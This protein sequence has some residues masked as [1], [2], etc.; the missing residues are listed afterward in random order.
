MKKTGLFLALISLLNISYG[1]M[2]DVLLSQL[3]ASSDMHVG[4]KISSWENNEWE[5]SGDIV[6]RDDRPIAAIERKPDAGNPALGAKDQQL[7]VEWEKLKT[8]EV[9]LLRFTAVA[10]NSEL[11]V[12]WTSVPTQP[13]NYFLVQRSQHKKQWQDL[14]IIL[15]P[16][17]MQPVTSFRYIDPYPHTGSNYYRLSQAGTRSGIAQSEVIAVEMMENGYHVLHLFPHAA[18]FG[19][20]IGLH[21]FSPAEVDIRMQ[22]AN[23]VE[24]GKVYSAQTQAGT[25]SIDIDLSA[26]P[27]GVYSCVIRVGDSVA[28]R[29]LVK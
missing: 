27:R 10:H 20:N 11:A 8:P 13:V 4:I 14:G 21:L 7:M 6:I 1:Q 28:V 15:A 16:R 18:I 24:V 12:E 26:L 2:G 25:H 19:A 17:D 5:L 3:L 9:G 23:G 29:E 22:D